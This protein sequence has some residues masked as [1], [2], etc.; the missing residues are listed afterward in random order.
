[1]LWWIRLKRFLFQEFAPVTKSVIIVV[2]ITFLLMLVLTS[3]RIFPVQS[4]LVLDT[5]NIFYRPWTLMT[6]P[7]VND[8]LSVIFAPLWLWFVGGSVERTWGSRRYGLFI[9]LVITITGLSMTGAGYL[10]GTGVI[11]AGL[12]MSLLGLTWVWAELN[13]FREVMLWGIIPVKA[14]WLAWLH[15]L[16]N[17]ISY[18]GQHFILGAASLMGILVAYFFLSKN[19]FGGRRVDSVKHSRERYKKERRSRLR[20]IK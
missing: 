3:L 4:F 15:A 2:G 6:Y 12:W 11:V 18:S 10:I 17:F 8:L 19:P 14:R 1:M 5:S 16:L 20:V 9:F 7:F 13:P